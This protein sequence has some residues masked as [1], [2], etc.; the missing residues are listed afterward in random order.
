MCKVQL[1]QTLS[2]WKGRGSRS[3]VWSSA[4]AA[5]SNVHPLWPIILCKRNKGDKQNED[6]CQVVLVTWWPP[7]TRPFHLTKQHDVDPQNARLFG[8]KA[9][10]TRG[11][12]DESS[13]HSG[14]N[15]PGSKCV[16]IC[17]YI[18]TH[19]KRYF[20]VPFLTFCKNLSSP[21]AIWAGSPAK[22]KSQQWQVKLW[23]LLCCHRHWKNWK[24]IQCLA[25]AE[26][27]QRRKKRAMGRF[28][29]GSSATWSPG[30]TF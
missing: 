23:A 6:K 13:L 19:R 22:K 29:T 10:I 9:R 25:F 4:R 12:V 1:R 2:S 17:I 16:C 8:K 26:M 5:P 24:N 14:P 7:K 28:D 20:R 18:Y 15:Y 11:K 21:G 27:C 3:N 30:H